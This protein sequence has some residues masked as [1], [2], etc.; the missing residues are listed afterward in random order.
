LI[1]GLLTS[2]H[3]KCPPA[4][5]TGAKENKQK[6]MKRESKG[7]YPRRTVKRETK[8]KGKLGIRRS[9][10]AKVEKQSNRTI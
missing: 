8:D 5:R 9:L 2:P 7:K 1:T 4:E 10:A 3:T 6:R